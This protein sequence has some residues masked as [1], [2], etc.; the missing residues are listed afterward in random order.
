MYSR[1]TSFDLRSEVALTEIFSFTDCVN[2]LTVSWDERSTRLSSLAPGPSCRKSPA[3]PMSLNGGTDNT[4]LTV[5]PP[6]PD[7]A[8]LCEL[9][10]VLRGLAPADVWPAGVTVGVTA[11]VLTT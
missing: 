4:G 10:E 3:P 11:G 1:T 6:S 5:A 9:V 2:C 7:D 8:V